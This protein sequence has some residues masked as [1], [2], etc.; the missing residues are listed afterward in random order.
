MSEIKI[1]ILVPVYN[2]E[3]CWLEAAINSVKNQTYDNWELCLL[4]DCSTKTE[5]RE[6][7]SKIRH[8][9]IKVKLAEVNT[10]IALATNTAAEMAD[11]DYLLLMDNDDE[12][13]TDALAE[14]VKKIQETGADIVYSDQ[15]IVDTEGNHRDPLCKPDWSPELL[16]SQMYIGH[17]LVFKKS[18]FDKV[19][20]FRKEY[21]GS[22]DYD[23]ML[24]MSRE[25]EHIE[26]VAKVL[27]SWRAIPTSTANNPESKPYAQ[28]AG[29][30]AVQDHLDAVYGV[31]KAKAYETDHLFVYDVRYELEKEP[32]VSVIIPTKDHVDL[33]KNAVDT[34]VKRTD[35]SDY[36][37]IILNNNSEK[38]ETFEYFEQVVL[39]N[40]IRVENAAFPFNWSKLNN[41]GMSVATGEVYIFLN[42]D[43]EIASREW[44]RRLVEKVTLPD[45]GVAGGLLL[46]EDN[47]IQHAGVVAS[48]GGW[49]DHVF[50]GMKPVHYGS[51]FVSPMVTRNVTAV[52]GA[53]LAISKK[54]VEKIGGFDE[55]FIIC[56]SDVE[57]S[58]RAIGQGLRTVYDPYVRLYHFE[59]KTRDSFIPEIDFELS[60]K[61]YRKYRENG[62]PYYNNQLDY[63]SCV[64]KV[65]GEQAAPVQESLQIRYEKAVQSLDFGQYDEHVDTH[66]AEINPYTLRSSAYN[67]KRINILL[68]SIN[69]EHVFGGIAT[70]LKFFEQLADKLGF[71]RR[72]ILVD[73]EPSDV[74]KEMYGDRYTFVSWDEDSDAEKQIVPY[75]AR[76][77]RSF[78]VGENDYF[79]LTGWWTSHCI[80]EA[81]ENY[82]METGIKPNVFINF[83]QDYEPG[84][85]AWSTHYLLADATYK[86]EY[87][88]IAIFNTKLLQ[89]YFHKND[90]SFYKEFA[91][92]PV[93]NK[94]LKDKLDKQGEFFRKKKQILVYGRPGTERNA[95]KLIVAA[96]KKWVS[97]QDDVEE[98]RILSAG[99]QHG[100][101]YLGRGK[102]L[103]SV[104]KLT[105]E[106]YADV[107]AESYAGISLMASPHPSYPPLEMSVFGVKVI[108][109]TFSNKD[110]NG[111]NQSMIAVSNISPNNIAHTLHDVCRNYRM[112]VENKNENPEYIENE[113]VFGFIEEIKEILCNDGEV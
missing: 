59:S 87:P 10:G 25:T 14:V 86:N 98:W 30:N 29:L 103:E 77:G 34:L 82:E 48:M 62:D 60:E 110:L 54:T 47:T 74:A 102:Y 21:T 70:A 51:P 11:G 94:G 27:Y 39:D 56:G 73:A 111:F 113:N 50:K 61:M 38:P 35:Y 19:G 42:N 43:V 105:I 24:R 49:A 71:A 20:G 79:M 26:H 12:L 17:V 5:V 84:F 6:Y 57:I 97:L 58:I 69:P 8:P 80:Q 81:Y 1:S 91:F 109:N 64:P 108:T 63:Y 55:D 4:D 92:D 101:V 65:K 68:P 22:Q 53:C 112:L 46:Y 28:T 67:E 32:K 45:I 36:E 106:G 16:L 75:S 99:E 107:L 18:L 44:M 13:S 2:V 85:Y 88:Q 93:L 72:I 95:F 37:I 33:L 40:R 78:P 9:K 100:K 7:L 15:D 83:I 96:L 52:T 23:L 31:G 76:C 90:Y 104:G 89:D 66:I 41:F 3:I